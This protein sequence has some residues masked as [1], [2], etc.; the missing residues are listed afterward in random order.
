MG[1]LDDPAEGASEEA[2]VNTGQEVEPA[3]VVNTGPAAKVGLAKLVEEPS[4][5]IPVQ[6]QKCET[7]TVPLKEA[8]MYLLHSHAEDRGV[9]P[10]IL[11]QDFI[12]ACLT[13]LASLKTKGTTFVN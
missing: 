13:R 4:A 5:T 12:T 10:E 6:L 11:A 8:T 2:V 3:G 7:V 9:T 1:I